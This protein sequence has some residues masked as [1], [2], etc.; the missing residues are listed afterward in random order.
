[1]L[2]GLRYNKFALLEMIGRKAM[3]P[4]EQLQ[5]SSFYQFIKE[6]GREE[7][8]R[9]TAAAFFRQLASKRL[10]GLQL[11]AE[12]EAV[13][14]AAKLQRLSYELETIPDAES[15]RRKLAELA[16]APQSATLRLP[17]LPR[18]AAEEN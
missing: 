12:V 13:G 11:G 8:R 16:E 10:P 5:G 2:G 9:E 15:L 6:E 3:S 18:L 7:G 14:D 4:P 1:M 17:G